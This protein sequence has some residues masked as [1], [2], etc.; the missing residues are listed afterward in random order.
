M[1]YFIFGYDSNTVID[2]KNVTMTI[3]DGLGAFITIT[4]DEGNFT[5]SEARARI[6]VKNRGILSTVKDGDETEMS[7]SFTARFSFYES[8]TD[9]KPLQFLK[10]KG[11]VLLTS[12]DDDPC[13]PFAVDIV[14]ENT[15]ACETDETLTFP[16]FRWETG[17][18]DVKAGTVSITGKCNA[19]EP[20][21]S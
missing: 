17:D 11:P 15:P 2:L 20:I 6:Y 19:T 1:I 16:D 10:N 5:W 14:L 12:T 9:I 3:Q 13:A 8:D 7:V 4:F 18:F 21:V